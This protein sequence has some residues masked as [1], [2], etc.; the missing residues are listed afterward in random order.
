[1][2]VK[3]NNELTVVVPLSAGAQAGVVP[4]EL[5]S[6]AGS[7]LTGFDLEGRGRSGCDGGCGGEGEEGHREG[8]ECAGWDEHFG[9]FGGGGVQRVC[10]WWVKY[11]CW[12]AWTPDGENDDKKKG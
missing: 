12:Y 2:A 5:S 3:R 9:G 8:G 10:L 1:M 11:Y 4:S 7:N 6:S